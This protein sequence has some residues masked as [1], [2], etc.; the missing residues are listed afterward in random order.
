MP[1]SKTI[2]DKNERA[3]E[4]FIQSTNILR[5]TPIRRSFGH[6]IAHPGI[7]VGPH[8]ARGQ[9]NRDVCLV[10]KHRID[11]P[12]N[13]PGP[14]RSDT[15]ICAECLDQNTRDRKRSSAEI[16]ASI[17]SGSEGSAV[18]PRFIGELTIR[19]VNAWEANPVPEAG[20]ASQC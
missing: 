19:C 16:D 15:R 3:T 8:T 11:R 13:G 14:N 5:H 7:V 9:R 17:A 12:D 4:N 20:C 2:R 6:W 1:N 10:S 18:L